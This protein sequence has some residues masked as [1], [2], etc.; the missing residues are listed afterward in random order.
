[1]SG[2]FGGLHR[3]SIEFRQLTPSGSEQAN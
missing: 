1:M 2:E 3:A